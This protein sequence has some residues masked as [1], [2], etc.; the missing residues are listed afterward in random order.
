MTHVI[1][2]R[3]YYDPNSDNLILINE[4]QTCLQEIQCLD[5]GGFYIRSILHHYVDL[6]LLTYNGN[7]W[8][9]NTIML[10]KLL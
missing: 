10:H 5:E 2:K 9:D 3:W 4:I 7:M 1:T 6:C 8:Q